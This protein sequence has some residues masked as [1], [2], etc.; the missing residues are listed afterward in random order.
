MDTQYN[1]DIKTTEIF[2]I[3]YHKICSRSDNLHKQTPPF[4]KVLTISI[5]LELFEVYIIVKVEIQN[6]FWTLRAV[7]YRFVYKTLL[8][9]IFISLK[10]IYI[11]Q[12][13]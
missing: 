13:F 2:K 7:K 11:F 4:Q 12:F 6:I 9:A 3:R 1:I 8:E 5:I 10:Y